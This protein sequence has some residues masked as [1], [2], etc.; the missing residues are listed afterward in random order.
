[1]ICLEVF[2]DLDIVRRLNCEHIFHKQC[3]DLWLQGQ[4]VNCPL[5]KSVYIARSE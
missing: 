2:S 5:C 1:A 4:H 3:I